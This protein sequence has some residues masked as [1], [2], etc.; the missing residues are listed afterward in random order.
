MSPDDVNPP[1]DIWGEGLSEP[2]DC[3]NC[4]EVYRAEDSDAPIDFRT[5]YCSHRCYEKDTQQMKEA[6]V[7][8]SSTTEDTQYT[9]TNI[10]GFIIKVPKAGGNK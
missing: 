9:T 7:D 4:G 5:T 8:E 10:G 3:F 1:V 2:R 6:A